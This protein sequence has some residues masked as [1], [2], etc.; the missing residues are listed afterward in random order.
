MAVVVSAA[1]AKAMDARVMVTDADGVWQLG[2][3]RSVAACMNGFHP[4]DL[5]T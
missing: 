4:V 3:A 5:L 1:K 2:Q